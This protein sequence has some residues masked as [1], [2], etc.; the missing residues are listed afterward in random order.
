MVVAKDSGVQQGKY[1]SVLLAGMVP[2]VNGRYP[3]DV[4]DSGEVDAGI[5]SQ[6]APRQG[7]YLPYLPV[8][9]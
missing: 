1:W 7:R 2:K 5:F 9:T 4:S 8:P 6:G 3:E